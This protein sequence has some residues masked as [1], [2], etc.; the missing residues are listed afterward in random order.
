MK[1]PMNFSWFIEGKLAAMAYPLETDFPFLIASGLKNIV[2]TTQHPAEYSEI[3]DANGITVHNI[4][5]QDYTP[6]SHKQIL[7]FLD[8]VDS[9]ETVGCLLYF[10]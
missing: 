4:P 7:E 10:P 2:N 3:A 9:A 1:S 6:P 5:V 8:I